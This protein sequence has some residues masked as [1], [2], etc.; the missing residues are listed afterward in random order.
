M[1]V[2]IPAAACVVTSLSSTIN[3]PS[4]LSRIVRRHMDRGGFGCSCRWLW[5]APVVG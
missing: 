3:P 5:R 2:R 4:T 1:V